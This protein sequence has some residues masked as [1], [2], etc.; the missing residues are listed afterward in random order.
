MLKINRL[1]NICHQHDLKQFIKYRTSKTVSIETLTDILGELVAYLNDLSLK[2]YVLLIPK[3]NY[4]T[5]VID[6]E[7]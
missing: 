5:F 4:E 3:N 1:L 2:Q 7:K 6:K